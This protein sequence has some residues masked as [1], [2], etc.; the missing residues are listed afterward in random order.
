MT[1]ILS[2]RDL[3]AWGAVPAAVGTCLVAFFIVPNYL[4][5]QSLKEQAATITLASDNYMVQRGGYDALRR[6]V[7]TL[8]DER[9]ALPRFAR[10]AEDSRLVSRV[11][12]RVD[13]RT[14]IDQ[15]IQMELPQVLEAEDGRPLPLGRRTVSVQMQGTFDEVFQILH[16]IDTS[17]EATRVKKVELS[18]IGNGLV[19]ARVDVEEWLRAPGTESQGGEL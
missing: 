10:N 8:R 4:R 9:E 17:R 11:S 3:V 12:R 13:G 15:A 19:N 7:E 18:A 6:E 5:A 1:R 14:V 2:I 16:D